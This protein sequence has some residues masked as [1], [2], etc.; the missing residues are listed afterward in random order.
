MSVGLYR[1]K[2]QRRSK[3]GKKISDTG[4]CALFLPNFDVTGDLLLNRPM[5][6]WNLPVKLMVSL[7]VYHST[8]ISGESAQYTTE[9][10]E[11]K[12]VVTTTATA[13]N[14][15]RDRSSWFVIGQPC[16]TTRCNCSKTKIGTITWW[17]SFSR[18]SW[19]HW[20]HVIFIAI[21]IGRC[22]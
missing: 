7:I 3:C 2:S 10:N 6:T 19:S 22:G 21:A 17:L 4:S 11:S 14:E 1:N 5:A 12:S 8:L 9:V 20:L 16:F 15:L 18:A 13:H